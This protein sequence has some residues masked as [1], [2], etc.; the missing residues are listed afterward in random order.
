M[1]DGSAI[2]VS[3]KNFDAGM[4]LP[5]KGFEK[6]IEQTNAHSRPWPAWKLDLARRLR[7]AVM[8]VIAAEAVRLQK[9]NLQLEA[10]NETKRRLLSEMSHDFR[11][12]LTDVMGFT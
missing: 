11:T 1:D 8:E 6:W 7:N 2:A 5:R 9:L 10:A 3:S 12:L 4:I